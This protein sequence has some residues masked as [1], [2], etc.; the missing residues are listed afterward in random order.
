MTVNYYTR[1]HVSVVNNYAAWHTVNYFTKEKVKKTKDKSN[2]NC[3]MIFSK[4][5]FPCPG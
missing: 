5:V 2:K 3:N 1:T 4:V